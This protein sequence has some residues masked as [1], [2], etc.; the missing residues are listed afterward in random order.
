MPKIDL[1]GWARIAECDELGDQ[2]YYRD[3]QTHVNE[4]ISNC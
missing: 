4:I 3:F 2:I 1:D